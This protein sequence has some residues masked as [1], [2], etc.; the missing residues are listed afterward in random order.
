MSTPRTTVITSWRDRSIDL[1]EAVTLTLDPCRIADV[2]L[3]AA[4]RAQ[5]TPSTSSR[6]R[7]ATTRTSS[8]FERGSTAIATTKLAATIGAGRDRAARVHRRPRPRRGARVERAS[9]RCASGDRDAD[10][11]ITIRPGTACAPTSS[12]M[13]KRGVR[14]GSQPSSRAVGA[15]G[16]E[17]GDVDRQL[18][19]RR[20]RSARAAWAPCFASST[21]CSAATTRSRCCAA[22]VIERDPTAAQRFLREARAAA[23]IRHP[24]IVD[25]F[26]FGYLADGRPYFVMELLEGESLAGSR[27]RAARCSRPRS[28]RSRASSRS[29]LA[30]RAR[31]RRHPRRRHAVERAR[32]VADD[33]P[34]H[35]KLVDFGLAALAGEAMHDED[36]RLRARHA[37]VHL[38]RAAARAAAR[39]IAATSTASA[40]CCSS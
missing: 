27:R 34:L 21:S 7:P 38:A 30:R 33:E 8:S 26:D 2:V 11:V 15:G 37:G 17:S 16:V 22:K 18:P 32:R 1:P 28:S 40:P 6:S 13:A 9:C 3:A 35:V 39:P 23:R 20:A 31:P 24:N 12:V 19:H 25:V 29:A 36:V 5:A 14:R 4:V 10:V